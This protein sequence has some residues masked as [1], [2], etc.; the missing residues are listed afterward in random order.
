VRRRSQRVVDFAIYIAVTLTLTA[1]LVWY[2]SASGPNGADLFGRWGGL[3]INTAI[4][5]GYMIN[6]SRED[7]S[8]PVFWV[9]A[10]AMLC[11]HVIVFTLILLHAQEWRVLWFLVM[12][13]TEIP[14]FVFFR[15]RAPEQGATRPATF[16]RWNPIYEQRSRLLHTSQGDVMVMATFSGRLETRDRFRM[17]RFSRL[18]KGY[19]GGFYD[20]G[21]RSG[22]YDVALMVFR[23]VTDL[24]IVTFDGL[25]GARAAGW[26]RAVAHSN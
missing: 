7:W 26:R 10:L 12:Y 24:E 17:S 22:G 5:F 18:S 4:L 1:G 9:L 6:D 3:A 13:P 19:G 2:A 21:L 11:A 16:L 15:K 20:V 25:P 23:Q 14:V 8:V